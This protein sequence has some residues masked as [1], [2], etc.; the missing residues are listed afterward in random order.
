MAA[1]IRTNFPFEDIAPHLDRHELPPSDEGPPFA[2]HFH[3]HLIGWIWGTTV[4][5]IADRAPVAA[6]VVASLPA[7]RTVLVEG[8]LDDATLALAFHALTPSPAAPS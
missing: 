5:E 4:V 6:W 1:K 2:V 8:S 7:K 3:S